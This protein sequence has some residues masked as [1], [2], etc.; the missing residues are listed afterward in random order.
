[1]R[2]SLLLHSSRKSLPD[3]P[4]TIIPFVELQYIEQKPVKYNKR[5]ALAFKIKG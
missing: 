3:L 1:M 4:P 5:N 2:A